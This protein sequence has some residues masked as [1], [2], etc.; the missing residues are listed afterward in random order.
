MPT[1]P[2]SDIAFTPAVKAIQTRKGSRALYERMEMNGGW[3]RYVDGPLQAVLAETRSAFLATASADGQPYIQHRGG[4]PGFIRALDDRTLGFAD[5]AGNRQYVSMGNAT[6]NA[7]T[8]LFLID[9]ARRRRIKIWGALTV[10]EDDAA[11]LARVTPEAV[12]TETYRGRVERAFVIRVAAWDVNCPQH[13]PQRFEAEDVGQAL[14]AKDARIA[15]LER[16]IAVLERGVWLKEGCA[17]AGD[18]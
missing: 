8:Q 10:V 1:P 7:R 5:F 18:D 17:G 4:P 9:Y 6:E 15:Q 11:L 13:I 12:R 3:S 14:A 2:A 16:E